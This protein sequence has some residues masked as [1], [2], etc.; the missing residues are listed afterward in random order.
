MPL[1]ASEQ[2]KSSDEDYQAM[3][4]K[5]WLKDN[6]PPKNAL[7][8]ELKFSF[9][10]EKLAEKDIYLWGPRSM[11][12]DSSR[13][14][15]VSDSQANQVFK[16]DS[17]GNFLFKFGRKGQG[18]G[19]LQNPHN[20]LITKNFIIVNDI[21]NNRVQLFDKN[22]SYVKILTLN[23]FYWDMANNEDSLIFAASHI[24][25]AKSPIIDV[26]T[27]DGQLLYSFGKPKEFKYSWDQL[28]DVKLAVSKKRELFMAFIHFPV[29]RR[30]SSKGELLAE[31]RIDQ[32]MMNWKEKMNLESISSGSRGAGFMV[33]IMSIRA[34]EN[35]FFILHDGPRIDILEFDNEGKQIVAYWIEKQSYKEGA[36]DFLVQNQGSEKLFYLLKDYP[37]NRV[38]VFM[39]K[40]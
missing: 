6:P 26:F 24:M 16:F 37:E 35:G 22:G 1:T 38:D 13:N 11:N 15:Y 21:G 10:S 4:W 33:I 9:P 20:V 36:K 32:K 8:L 17:S 39:Q 19:D 25:D 27:Q 31:F 2:Q 14:I 3:M 28:N 30:Y 23:K 5:N 7:K 12:S 34:A 29:V 40:H 18:P